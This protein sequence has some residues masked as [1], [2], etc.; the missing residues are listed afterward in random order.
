VS[1]R[2]ARRPPAAAREAA[3]QMQ[4]AVELSGQ[5]AAEVE[6]WHAESQ[7]LTP[8][9]RA[10]AYALVCELAARRERIEDLI[11]RHAIGWRL[12]RMTAVD[13]SILKIAAAELLHGAKPDDVVEAALALTRKFSQPDAVGFIHAILDAIVRELADTAQ[14]AR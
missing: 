5:Q 3:L 4:Y 12:E 2:G 10:A 7:P 1:P 14:P 13:R 8:A 6:R 11:A 9:V